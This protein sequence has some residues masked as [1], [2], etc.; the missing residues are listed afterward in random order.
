MEIKDSDFDEILCV[1]GTKKQLNTV[2]KYGETA[3]LNQIKILYDGIRLAIHEPNLNLTEEE[4]ADLEEIEVYLSEA[5][6]EI[7]K[8]VKVLNKM[9]KIPNKPRALDCTNFHIEDEALNK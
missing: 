5:R 3:L 8:A 2:I 1:S 7:L 9:T 6:F 4:I